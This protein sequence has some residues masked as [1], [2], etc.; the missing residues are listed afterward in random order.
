LQTIAAIVA[1]S[2]HDQHPV[3][4]TQPKG[5]LQHAVW[6]PVRCPLTAADVDDVGALLDG[7]LDC[8]SEVQLR[9]P[10]VGGV[11]E[12]GQDEPPAPR[13]DTDNGTAGLAKQQAGNVSA[14]H[15]H[16]PLA[17]GFL[18]HCVEPREVGA[19][20]TGVRQVDRTVQDRDTDPGVA[21]QAVCSSKALQH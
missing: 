6:P 3:V 12:D 9:H 5:S 16:R 11:R 14:V 13:S 17:S 1:H 10:A 21:I 8:P 15:R 20:K 7:L 18:H 4:F 2:C 19:A